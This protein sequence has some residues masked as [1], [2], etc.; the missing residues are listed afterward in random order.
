[1]DLNPM[2]MAKLREQ[3]K[4]VK[5]EIRIEYQENRMVVTMNS[6]DPGCSAT[7]RSLLENLGAQFAQVMG[8]YMGIPG[9]IVEVGKDG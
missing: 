5:A 2:M 7:I 1:M 9:E 3:L 6:D 4:G 8:T